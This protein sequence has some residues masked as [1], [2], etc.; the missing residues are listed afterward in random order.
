MGEMLRLGGDIEVGGGCRGQGDTEAGGDDEVWG[1][2]EVG[3]MLRLKGDAEAG[4]DAE[5]WGGR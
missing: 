1:D 4:G 3:G 5:V 2:A